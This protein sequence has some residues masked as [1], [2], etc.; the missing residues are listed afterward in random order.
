MDTYTY[1]CP[2][3]GASLEFD[4]KAGLLVCNNCGQ[5]YRADELPGAEEIA[6]SQPSYA[7]QQ[8]YTSQPS[9]TEQQSYTSQPLY[10]EQQSYTSQ[11]AYSAPVEQASTDDYM[12]INVYHCSSCGSEIMTNDVEASKLCSYCGQPTIMFDRVSRERKPKKIIPFVLNK[13]QALA[14]AKAKYSGARYLMD[15][16]DSI[17]VE[18][19]NAIYMPYYAYESKMSISTSIT[20]TNNESKKV[21]YTPQASKEHT[22][23]LDASKRFNDYASKQLNPFPASNM[24]D[25]HPAYLSGFYADCNDVSADDRTEDAKEYLRE[26]LLEN[27]ILKTPA[28]P[29]E[30]REV[31]ADLYRNTGTFRAEII[32]EE[33]KLLDRSYLFVPVFFITFKIADE[34]IILLVNGCTGKVVGTIPVDENKIARKQTKDSILFG[35]I[36][37][38]LGALL[39]A[40]LPIWW[41]GMLFVIIAGSMIMTGS[42]AKKKYDNLAFSIN[43]ESMFDLTKR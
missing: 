9:Y 36:F 42:K 2:G 37:A 4:P 13:E 11:P 40:Y 12:D 1:K 31:Y 30:M 19:V 25:F 26:I 17:S 24:V 35:I 23:M 5:L 27:A 18:S 32:S 10:A 29:R 38:L 21:T 33:Y 15:G 8:S 20:M 41:S 39:F 6:S 14:R 34:L 7:E 22:V 16:L 43:S 3:C 28:P